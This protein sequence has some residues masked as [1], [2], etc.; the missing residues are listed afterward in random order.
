ML[1]LLLGTYNLFITCYSVTSLIH[2][3]RKNNITANSF[4]EYEEENIHPTT[5]QCVGGTIDRPN[6]KNLIVQD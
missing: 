6:N 5:I 1:V 2:K 4:D 3:E